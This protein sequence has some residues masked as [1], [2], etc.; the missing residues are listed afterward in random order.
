M[1]RLAASASR[2]A[3]RGLRAISKN[4]LPASA[5][6]VQ[7]LAYN[8][9]APTSPV[10]VKT[11]TPQAA[12]ASET[13][14]APTVT[15]K[16]SQVIGAVVDVQFGT[17][18]P[19]SYFNVLILSPDPSTFINIRFLPIFSSIFTFFSIQLKRVGFITAY[20]QCPRGPGP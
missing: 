18:L 4:A 6:A 20:S 16:I 19:V 5:V 2:T 12:A 14:A 9:L 13:T 17:S 11:T 8:T 7:R 3:S 1:L 15:G 10:A